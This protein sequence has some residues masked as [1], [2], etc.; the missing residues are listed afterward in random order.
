MKTL[1]FGALL[2]LCCARTAHAGDQTQTLGSHIE[3]RAWNRWPEHARGG[4][5]PLFVDVTNRDATRQRITL[6]VTRASWRGAWHCDLALELAAGE[7]QRV[8]VL[9]PLAVNSTN[10]VSVKATLGTERAWLSGVAGS[11]DSRTAVRAILVC[12]EVSPAPGDVEK[13]EFAVSTEAASGAS[14][15]SGTPYPADVNV[16][17]A[18]RDELSALPA[19]YSCLD[20]VVIDSGSPWPGEREFAAITAWMR[21]GGDVLVLGPNAQ[22]LA[23]AQPALAAWMEPRFDM[24]SASVVA[25]AVSPEDEQPA[26]PSAQLQPTSP[27]R[28]YRAALGRLTIAE[29]DEFFPG[30]D[31]AWIHALLNSRSLAKPAG[32]HFRDSGFLARLELAQLPYRVFAVLL[33]AFAL[34]IGPLNFYLV[35]QRKRPVLLLFTIPAIS[36]SVTVLLLAY[37]IL[38]QGLD[39]KT[40]S[41]SI[42]ALDQRAHN[43]STIEKRQLFAGLS[44]ADG[45]RPMTGTVVQQLDRVSTPFG[46]DSEDFQLRTRHGQEWLLTGDFMPARRTIAQLLTCDRAERGRLEVEFGADGVEVL[47]N[48]GVAL[49]RMSVRDASGRVF[50]LNREL[51]V[52]ARATLVAPNALGRSELE[53]EL[54]GKSI[55]WGPPSALNE[56]LVPPGCYVAMLAR[57]AY[58]DS[59][60]IELNEQSGQHLLFGVLELPAEARR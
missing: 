47:N 54:R 41:R 4:W 24:T 55:D 30:A 50:E 9:V 18:R 5:A 58:L 20:L 60:G 1:V 13:W 57:G 29:T 43:A 45:L 40:A 14:P 51:A 6:E 7:S 42:T 59:C 23:A 28:S 21:T 12:S 38:Y 49:Q 16:A 17:L 2:A 34:L 22:R 56:T 44:P 36:A 11:S 15:T 8:E 48:L 31:P 39:V 27:G 25:P 32:N 52:G 26:E 3:L 19:A 46:F 35:G 37:G 10:N 53:H 33:I